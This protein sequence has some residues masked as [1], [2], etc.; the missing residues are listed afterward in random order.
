MKKYT[1]RERDQ[2]WSV[3]NPPRK[4]VGHDDDARDNAKNAL[5]QLQTQRTRITALET[6]LQPEQ[7]RAT[8]VEQEKNAL[9]Q[10]LTTTLSK[11]S[12]KGK[13]KDEG[14][15]QM[16]SIEKKATRKG[17]LY[18][19]ESSNWEEGRLGGRSPIH[20]NWVS[21]TTRK[22]PKKDRVTEWQRPREETIPVIAREEG[23]RGKGEIN[24]GGT[25]AQS[26][27]E[28]GARVQKGAVLNLCATTETNE[29]LKD[30]T[31]K[32]KQSGIGTL[33]TRGD[34]RDV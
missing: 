13:S 11:D 33:R 20:W 9:I 7:I 16:R 14:Q 17:R 23:A 27:R 26:K 28:E 32:R 25:C 3:I 1:V 8:T 5:Q 21:A 30:D 34:G 12:G 15:D 19:A 29:Q 22:K 10:T 2:Y 6:H 24:S 4:N 31:M 18:S